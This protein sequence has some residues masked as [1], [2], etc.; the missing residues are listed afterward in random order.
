VPRDLAAW[1]DSIGPQTDGGPVGAELLGTSRRAGV[2]ASLLWNGIRLVRLHGSGDGPSLRDALVLL[3]LTCGV[4]PGSDALDAAVQ[5]GL[6]EERR[7]VP[8]GARTTTAQP[9]AELTTWVLPAA[10]CALVSTRGSGTDA[11]RAMEQ[12]LRDVAAA[13]M[14]VR[15]P[16]GAAPPTEP[17]GEGPL[18][19]HALAAGWLATQLWDAGVVGAPETFERTVAAVVGAP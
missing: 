10:A 16:V 19:G 11:Y 17:P 4:T 18:L 8:A 3:A 14:V 13:L 6:A 12:G 1:A 15:V 7:R 2:Y 5:A 9:V